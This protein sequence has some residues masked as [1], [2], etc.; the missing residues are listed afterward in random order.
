MVELADIQIILIQNQAVQVAVLGQKRQAAQILQDQEHQVKVTQA[1]PVRPQT[2]T[3]VA[4]AALALLAQM[5]QQQAAAM[6]AM[7]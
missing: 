6:A 3:Q 7:V 2:Q 5:L 1:A 4:E